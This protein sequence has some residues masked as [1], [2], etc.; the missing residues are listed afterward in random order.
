MDDLPYRQAFERIRAEYLEMPGMRL[1]A[2]Q[3]QRLSGVDISTCAVVL[4]DLVRARFLDRGSDGS[5][6]RASDGDPARSRMSRSQWAA[7]PIS[8]SRRARKSVEIRSVGPWPKR[9]GATLPLDQA[10]WSRAPESLPQGC[11]SD[12]RRVQTP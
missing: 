2:A 5:Y 6:A 10:V 7:S 12:P 9:Y 11:E 3:V 1:T 8:W 4:E